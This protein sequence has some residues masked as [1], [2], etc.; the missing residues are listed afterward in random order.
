MPERR[1]RPATV[2]A[3]LHRHKGVF[4]KVITVTRNYRPETAMQAGNGMHLSLWAC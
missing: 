1:I 4:Q 3:A 2:H